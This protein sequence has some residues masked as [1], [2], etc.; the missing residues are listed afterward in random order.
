MQPVS[1]D[2]LAFSVVVS[3]AGVVLW[4]HDVGQ[5]ANGARTVHVY[6]AEWDVAA[7]GFRTVRFGPMG[8]LQGA[9]SVVCAWLREVA[10]RVYVS[11]GGLCSGASESSAHHMHKA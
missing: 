9:A 1:N 5:F 10:R 11:G 3:W 7:E 2:K 6:G 4:S 8:H